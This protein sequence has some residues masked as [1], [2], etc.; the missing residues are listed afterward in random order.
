MSHFAAI[1]ISAG[2]AAEVQDVLVRAFERARDGGAVGAAAQGS[3]ALAA[4]PLGSPP[5]TPPT[6]G[7]GP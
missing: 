4:I 2:D 7:K 1:G 6:E 3:E 5:T